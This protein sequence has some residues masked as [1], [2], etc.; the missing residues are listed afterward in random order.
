MKEE[1]FHWVLTAFLY[2]SSVALWIDSFQP[3]YIYCG[4]GPGDF[5]AEEK[6]DLKAD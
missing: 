3:F 4:L 1:I 5:L 2:C 6:Q